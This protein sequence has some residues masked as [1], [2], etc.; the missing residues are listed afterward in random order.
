MSN[1]NTKLPDEYVEFCK[2]VAKLAAKL[3]LDRMS[4]TIRPGY[5]STWQSDINMNWNTGRHGDEEEAV[6]ISSQVE[7]FT[8][9]NLYGPHP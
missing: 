9:V 4:M 1:E 7:I 3:K 6:R 8:K 5:D 2:Q